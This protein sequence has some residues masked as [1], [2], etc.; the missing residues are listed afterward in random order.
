MPRVSII[1]PCFNEEATIELLLTAIQNQSISIQDMEV[2][3]G[4]GMSTDRTRQQIQA[5][6]E[7][8]PQM[9]IKVVDNVRRIIPAG[10]NRALEAAQGDYIVRLDG[11]SQPAPDYVARCLEA[12]ENGRGDNV[13]GLWQIQPRSQS[14]VA[15]AVAAAAAHP[16]AVGDA[17]YRIGGQAQAVDT[18]PFGAFHRSLVKRIGM[19]DESL[20]SNEDYEF[21]SR[22]RKSGGVVWF[23]PAIRSTYFAPRNFAALARQYARYGFWK[24]RMLQRYPETLRWRQALPP[25][26]VLALV[27]ASA[28]SIG[29]PEARLW[30]VLQL[31]VYIAALILAGLQ[32]AVKKRDPALWVGL[33]LAVATMHLS[34]GGAFLWSSLRLILRRN[35]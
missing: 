16:L 9:Q 8:H 20:L 32:A 29:L 24:V 14:W 30:L 25:L 2:I 10:L 34:W 28:L 17:R 11:H 21:N 26:F 23:D 27:V 15:R 7:R 35:G 5:F 3:I 12:L 33:P 19:Y 13:G 18:V 22:I 6:Q 31:T 4:D 1:V